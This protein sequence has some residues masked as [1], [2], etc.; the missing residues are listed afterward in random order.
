M[1]SNIGAGPSAPIPELPRCVSVAIYVLEGTQRP[2]EATIQRIVT[3]ESACPSGMQ[4][5]LW[6]FELNGLEADT[7]YRLWFKAFHSQGEI[8]AEDVGNHWYWRQKGNL[9][10]VQYRS[11]QELDGDDNRAGVHSFTTEF[12]LRTQ[13]VGQTQMGRLIENHNVIP[14]ALLAAIEQDGGQCADKG[15]Y[16]HRDDIGR[17]RFTGVNENPL[18]KNRVCSYADLN[19]RMDR[20]E[21]AVKRLFGGDGE[22]LAEAM[23][24]DP[25]D[26]RS[27]FAD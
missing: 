9:A 8:A 27:F 15:R 6:D 3:N 20:A 21:C 2:H 22:G 23:G 26:C 25:G 5:S 12:E 7:A 13:P 17:D 16:R 1:G 4:T 10:G 11:L 19:C 24:Y 14:P 18:P